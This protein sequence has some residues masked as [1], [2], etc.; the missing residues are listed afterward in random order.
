MRLQEAAVRVRLTAEIKQHKRRCI[1]RKGKKTRFQRLAAAAAAAIQ[2]E[3]QR[4]G[5]KKFLKIS[6]VVTVT[7]TEMGRSTDF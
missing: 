7:R 4:P 2:K 1:L 5:S 6:P 3:K